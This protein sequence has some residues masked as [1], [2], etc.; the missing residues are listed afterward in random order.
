MT[1][2]TRALSRDALVRILA[3]LSGV[4]GLLA[5]LVLIVFFIVEYNRGPVASF[6]I[7]HLND[8]LGAVQFATLAPVAW[9]L[10]QR[11]PAS[12]AVRVATVVAVVAMVAFAVLGILLVTYVL[13]FEQQ[14]G[15]VMVTIIVI[16][17]WLLAVNLVGH[18]TQALPREVTRFGVLLGAGF[19][20]AIA[21]MG[22]GYLLPE[23]AGQLV[24]WV[25][26]AVAAPAWLALPVYVLLLATR[27]FSHPPSP[28]PATA[29]TS[30]A[31]T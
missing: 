28:T 11:L 2:S 18:R 6:S 4:V 14:I 29:L 19:L 26:Y 15:P 20:V 9:A 23:V 24:T 16:Y 22:A 3:L 17:G 13:T 25:G 7:G 31:G 12:R 8:V 21:L 10:G 27:V 1:T 5:G 30:G